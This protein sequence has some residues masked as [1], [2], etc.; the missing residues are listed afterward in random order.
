METTDPEAAQMLKWANT[1]DSRIQSVSAGIAC[2]LLALHLQFQIKP[3]FIE[4]IRLTV[5]FIIFLITLETF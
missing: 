4:K 3:L 1:V 2:L 5:P